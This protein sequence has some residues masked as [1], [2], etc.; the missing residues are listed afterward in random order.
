M[1][2]CLAILACCVAVSALAQNRDGDSGK[3]TLNLSTSKILKTPVVGEPQRVGSFPVNLA[4]SPDGRYAAILDD[5]YGNIEN[6]H[7]QGIGILDLQTNELKFFPD[8]RLRSRAH[9]TY[10]IGIGF[11]GDGTRLYASMASLSDPLAKEKGSTGNGIAVYRFEQG[12]IAP[13]RFIAVPP[14]PVADGKRVASALSKAPKGTA[15]P[16]PAGL[17]VVHS[18][19]GEQLLVADNL[20]DDVLLLDAASGRIVHR[21]DL[22]T[23]NDIPAAY[24]YTVVANRAGTRA[25]CSL[26]NASRVAELDLASGKLV[27]W[28]SLKAPGSAT[29]A[30]S[31][32]T[33]LMLS[34]KERLLFVTLSNRDAVAI[35]NARTGRV[36]RYLSTQLT[37]EKFPG[38]YPNALAQTADGQRVFVANASSDAVAVFE[39]TSGTSHK[40][41]P[42]RRR[43]QLQGFVPTEWYPTALGV[44]GDD[45]LIATGK[46]QGPGPNSGP[47]GH[48][49]HVYIAALMNGSIARVG[50][51]DAVKNMASLTREVVE[52]NRMNG[53]SDRVEFNAE[54][55][56]QHAMS[57]GSATRHHTGECNPIK[58]VIY[59]IKENR[60]YDQLFGDLGVGD[61]DP[62]LVMYGEEISPNHHKLARQFGVLDNFYDSGEISG[63]G[64]VWSTAAITSDYTEK[65]WQISYRGRERSYDYEGRVANETPLEQGI[66]DVDEPGSGYLWGNAA[67]HGVT[68]R[69][70][71]EFV[72]TFWC[73]EARNENPKAGTPLPP[74]QKCP[75]KFVKQGEFLPQN[76]GDPHGGGSPWPWPIPIIARNVA[77]K[78]ELRGHFD[79]RFADFRVDYP[80]QLRADEFLNEFQRFVLDRKAGTDTM[81][82]LIVLRLPNDHTG[83]TRPGKATPAASVA[84]NDLA[85][86]RVV[87]AV[88]HSDYW[89]DTAIFVLEDDAQDGAD[90]VDAHRSIALI[91]SKYAPRTPNPLVHHEFYTTVNVIHTM[92][93]LLGLPPM[94]NNDAQAPLMTPLF[95]GRGE[96]PAFSADYRNRDN[97]LL[98]RINAEKAAGAEASLKMDFSRADAVDTQAL[99]RILW[100]EAK[101]DVTMPEPRFSVIPA[102]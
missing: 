86:G 91:I 39:L 90:H 98:Y 20:S 12:Q 46:A 43:Y 18:T 45:L 63:N 19:G 32:P 85:L 68:Y 24:P 97:G 21:F 48:K 100:R 99:N 22:S 101:G 13:E 27:R 80:D 52:S 36:E 49:G 28:I 31:H 70:Y 82:R 47:G 17:A 74:G 84:D 64:H 1:K 35:V 65:T 25:W 67:R 2:R 76:V 6:E 77:T 87:E 93:A 72:S 73:D 11:S 58:H 89:D 54:A 81:P 79:P 30:G 62:S 16:Y 50:V 92:E 96:Q 75:T 42:G 59:V 94:N 37:K 3:K 83:G 5:G 33:A 69:H 44:R 7:Q 15:I 10:F 78:P 102:R 14:Q 95:A 26:W 66:P 60:T 40:G 9:Q 8:G 57:A 38:T 53:R 71:G 56:S 55:C 34:P 29:A 4:L 41:A 88:S 23:S 51:A 61:G